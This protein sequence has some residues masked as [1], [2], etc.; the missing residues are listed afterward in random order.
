[1]HLLA[2]GYPD[3]ATGPEAMEELKRSDRDLVIRWN[4]IAAVVRDERGTFKTFT[5]AE[6]TGGQPSWAMFWWHLF[7]GLFFVPIL[8]MP[9]GSGLEPSLRDV[10]GFSLDPVFE[11]KV[12]H[13][14]VADTSALFVLVERVE[15]D[16]VVSALDGFGG[17][18]FRN[19]IS[20]ELEAR[21]EE[22]L[23]GRPQVA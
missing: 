7:A 3:P 12:R 21:L 9:V 22:T 2:I 13:A 11:E 14:M 1:M 15:P 19:D 17:S 18:I 5:N 23:N 8:E 16:T 6:I 20:S 4:E 10:I